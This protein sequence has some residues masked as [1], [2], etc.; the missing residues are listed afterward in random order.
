MEG[1]E[2]LIQA[3]MSVLRSR[4]KHENIVK[5]ARMGGAA[6]AGRKLSEEHKARLAQGQAARRERERAT[7]EAAGLPEPEPKRPRGRPRKVAPQSTESELDGQ[8][9]TESGETA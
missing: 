3:A 7:K 1:E 4:R 9:A 2:E 8:S 6:G 5:A